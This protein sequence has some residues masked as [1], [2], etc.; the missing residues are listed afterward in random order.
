MGG[1]A[2]VDLQAHCLALQAKVAARLL[3]PRRAPWKLFMGARLEQAMPGLGTAALVQATTTA[4]SAAVRGGRLSQRHAG[5]VQAFQQVGLQRHVARGDMSQQQ[6]LLEPLVGNHSVGA[7]T[8]GT[9]FSSPSHLP[10]GFTAG[11]VRPSQLRDVRHQLCFVPATDGLVLPSAWQQCL[12]SPAPRGWECDQQQQWARQ[13][14]AGQLQYY[15][16]GADG[17]LRQMTLPP[18]TAAAVVWV[19]CC[20]VDVQQPQHPAALALEQQRRQQRYQRMVQQAQS[21]GMQP[22]PP[23]PSPPPVYFLVGEW[24]A[25]RVDPSVWGFGQLE[26]VLQ[27]TVKTATLRLLQ[28][29]MVGVLGWEPG[30]GIRP[31]L[32]F[33]FFFF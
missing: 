9:M 23:L 11:H 1:M 16:V 4:V 8:D 27:Y 6:V 18:P 29:Q 33:F 21:S 10:G 7:A 19:Q 31:R 20:V 12:T 3:H 25:I 26:G 14:A 22:P 30:V 28:T 32:F 17:M 13:E 24:D 2:Q 15:A 5:Y